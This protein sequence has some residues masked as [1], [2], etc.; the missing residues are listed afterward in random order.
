MR[1]TVMSIEEPKSFSG[2]T[3]A[4]KPYHFVQRR[5]TLWTGHRTVDISERL[6]DAI[7]GQPVPSFSPLKQLTNATFKVITIRPNGSLLNYDVK[8]LA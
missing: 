3:K 4:G 6:E 1:G 5:I 8:H 7:S 2:I